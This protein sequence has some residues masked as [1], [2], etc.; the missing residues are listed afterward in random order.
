[1]L[2]AANRNRAARLR[3]VSLPPGGYPYACHIQSYLDRIVAHEMALSIEKREAPPFGL[4]QVAEL[5]DGAD[6]QPARM[7]IGETLAGLNAE[8]PKS[9]CEPAT[10]AS[11]LRMSNELAEL[12]GHRTILVEGYPQVAQAVE[13]GRDRAKLVTYLLQRHCAIL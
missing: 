8:V 7:A 12:G 9:M 5:I 4:L 6:R 13:R 3:R 2:G 1:M 10:L 11:V